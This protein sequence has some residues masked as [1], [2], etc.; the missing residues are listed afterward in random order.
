MACDSSRSVSG[1]QF[2]Y[3]GGLDEVLSEILLI[4]LV[5]LLWLK[6]PL[7]GKACRGRRG[8]LRTSAQRSLTHIS[9]HELSKSSPRWKLFV[10]E[11]CFISHS[12]L[13]LGKIRQLMSQGRVSMITHT[14]TTLACRMSCFFP[15]IFLLCSDAGKGGMRWAREQWMAKSHMRTE[16]KPA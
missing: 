7:A 13:R 2:L 12:S 5:C 8:L 4:L 11:L 16:P 14:Y 9:Q 1:P 3:L 10:L 6:S 15:L